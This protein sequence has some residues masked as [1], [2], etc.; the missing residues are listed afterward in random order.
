MK[1]GRLTA[2]QKVEALGALAGLEMSSSFPPQS[3]AGKTRFRL[4]APLI[5]CDY[6]AVR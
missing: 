2:R 6:L 5:P 4:R 3:L 1:A